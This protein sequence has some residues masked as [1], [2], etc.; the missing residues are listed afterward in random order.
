[1]I[2]IAAF[3]TTYAPAEA[4]QQLRFML[5]IIHGQLS[6][7]PHRFRLRESDHSWYNISGTLPHTAIVSYPAQR[8]TKDAISLLKTIEPSSCD[9]ITYMGKARDC[10]V[11]LGADLK[12]PVDFIL[13]A[14]RPVER[15]GF[16]SLSHVLHL[17]KLFN[18][19]LY[20]LDTTVGFNHTMS[21]L[22]KLR[23]E[24]NYKK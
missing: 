7:V 5:Q 19:P 15:I 20:N 8:A 18:I 23:K 3:T 9:K 10:M 6:I 12:K 13:V 21:H 22:E 17:S 1:M 11:V 24:H 4:Q 16:S 2:R 14:T